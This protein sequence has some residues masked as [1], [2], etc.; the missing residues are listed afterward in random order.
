MPA[1]KNTQRSLSEIRQDLDAAKR[2]LSGLQHERQ[3]LPGRIKEALH[4]DREV[5]AVA[6]KRGESVKEVG[7]SE[8]SD[9]R[10][11]EAEIP[12]ELWGAE[13]NVAEL[14]AEMAEYR[15]RELRTEIPEAEEARRAAQEAYREASARISTAGQRLTQLEQEGSHQRRRAKQF[16]EQV[17]GLE[18]RGPDA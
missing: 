11:R 7:D 9:L 16:R 18:K 5:K 10:A 4:R 15:E 12:D 6:A 3:E 13:L 14:N 17:A 2:Q 8:L 1:T